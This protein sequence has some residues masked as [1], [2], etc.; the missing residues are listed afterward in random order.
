LIRGGEVI[1]TIK[2]TTPIEL[3][4]RDEG[5][6]EGKQTYYRI[7]DSKEHLVSNPIFVVYDS[8]K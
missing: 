8:M 2:G 1:K 6:P 3:E 7:M 4:Y 5:I